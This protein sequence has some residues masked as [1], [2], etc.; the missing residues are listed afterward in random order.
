[1]TYGLLGIGSGYW[2][3][4]QRE[5]A[6]QVAAATVGRDLPALA[7]LQPPPVA[8]DAPPDDGSARLAAAYWLAVAARIRDAAGDTAGSS[9][10]AGSARMALLASTGATFPSTPLPTPRLLLGQG[11]YRA[12]RT[13]LMDAAEAAIASG[14]PDVGAV[15]QGLTDVNA[16]RQ[17]QLKYGNQRAIPA[18]CAAVG[19][20]AVV[21]DP[22]VQGS[23][24]PYIAVAL[25]VGAGAFLLTRGPKKRKTTRR[26]RI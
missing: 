8:L 2:D 16:V 10:L 22:W 9:A 25:G 14:A 11:Q 4:L 3:T 26:R 13:I 17:S 12:A 24:A 20:P 1:M 7:S 19:V 5:A 23:L 18:A 15:L 21:C 6:S